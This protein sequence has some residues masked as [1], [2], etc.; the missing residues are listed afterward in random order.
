[1]PRAAATAARASCG[2]SHR[3]GIARPPPSRAR[4]SR[5]RRRRSLRGR[6][7]RTG[8][9]RPPPPLPLRAPSSH[10]S[11]AAASAAPARPPLAPRAAVAAG[12]T[13]IVAVWRGF[14]DG[15]GSGLLKVVRLNRNA[16]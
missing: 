14:I 9:T 15:P 11:R 16:P 4:A 5:G 3:S 12:E 7:R 8:L 2:R 10:G 1:V 13:L 6:C